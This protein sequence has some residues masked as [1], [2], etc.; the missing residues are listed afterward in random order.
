MCCL[1]LLC[2][3]E[4]GQIIGKQIPDAVYRHIRYVEGCERLG[5]VCVLSLSG[6][7][8]GDAAAPFFLHRG[9]DSWLIIHQNVMP[10]RIPY[11]DVVER[12]LFMDVN[13]HL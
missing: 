7:Y 11:R 3:N 10:R 8:G 12:E 13:Q 6:K 5:V 1:G 2:C 4:S 9:E